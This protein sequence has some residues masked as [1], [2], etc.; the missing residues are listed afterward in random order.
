MFD[1]VA[2]YG[3]GKDASN[4]FVGNYHGQY[5]SYARKTGKGGAGSL[6]QGARGFRMEAT[7]RD[8]HEDV[9]FQSFII[10]EDGVKHADEM[11]NLPPTYNFVR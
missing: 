5:L 3:A 7:K 10:D 8:G 4:D 6:K 9:E 2:W 1:H 11:R